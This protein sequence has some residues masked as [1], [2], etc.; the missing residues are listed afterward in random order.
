LKC[1]L[2]LNNLRERSMMNEIPT[3]HISRFT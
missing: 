1:G 2:M 3:T